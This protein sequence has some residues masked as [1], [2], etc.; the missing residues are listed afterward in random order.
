MDN[1]YFFAIDCGGTNLRV[2]VLDNNLNIVKMEVIKSITDNPTLLYKNIK[3]LLISISKE[4]NNEVHYIGVSICG[5]VTNNQ[6]GRCANIGI[7]KSFDFYSKLKKDFPF[8][9]IRIANDANATALAEAS[10]G[11]NKD[12]SNSIF[13]TIS[14]GIG[15]GLVLNGKL[16]ETPFEYGRTLIQYKG[17][18]DELEHFISGGGIVSLSKINGLKIKNAQEFFSLVEKNDKN[19]LKVLSEWIN[20]ASMMFANMQLLYNVDRYALSGGVMKSSKFFLKDL[21]I[22]ANEKI[23][24]WNLKKIKLV[25]SKFNQDA[26]LISAGVLALSMK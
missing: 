7:E 12:V 9:K 11:T 20:L 22:K 1:K 13:V 23:E 17:K 2:A 4:V 10:I 26:G 18:E 14:T 8:A 16:V 6:V 15:A 21:E 24:K 5:V 3:E 19:A 25:K